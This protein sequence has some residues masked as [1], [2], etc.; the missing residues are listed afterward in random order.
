MSTEKEALILAVLKRLKVS[1]G[2]DI[3]ASAV[4]TMDG[5]LLAS[6]MKPETDVERFS[7]MCA[8][9]LAL[10]DQT[11][12]EVAIGEMQQVMIMGTNGISVLTHAGS[13]AV[14]AL[15]TSARAMQGRV[16]MESKR[17]AG[18]VARLLADGH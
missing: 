13:D 17:A 12:A 8:S 18:E 1:S 4:V 2:G 7:S 6:D 9:L 10:A 16:L 14:L 11:L 15:S 5:Y 3:E